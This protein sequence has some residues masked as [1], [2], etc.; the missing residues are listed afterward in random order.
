MLLTRKGN[1]NRFW[2]V[3]F[4]L[5]EQCEHIFRFASISENHIGQSDGPFFILL[6]I[7]PEMVLDCFNNINNVNLVNNIN[8]INNI[9]NV[10]NVN[11]VKNV[12]NINNINDINNSA[13][14]TG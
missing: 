1:L 2:G 4:F 12:N 7:K 13:L 5:I 9:N 8:Y 6:Q 14:A 3:G 10:N 11:N